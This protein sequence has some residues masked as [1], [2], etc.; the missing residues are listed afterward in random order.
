MNKDYYNGYKAHDKGNPKHPRDWWNHLQKDQFEGMVSA[1]KAT[2]S[3]KEKFENTYS[4][5]ER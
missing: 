4:D 1:N 2:A 5:D 3:W